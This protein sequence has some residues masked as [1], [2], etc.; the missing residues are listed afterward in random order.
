MALRIQFY[1]VGGR[2]LRVVTADS[3][4]EQDA[5]PTNVPGATIFRTDTKEAWR[6]SGTEWASANGGG[7]GGAAGD[8]LL[9]QTY[10]PSATGGMLLGSQYVP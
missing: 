7:G 3:Q 6:W 1:Y 4:V 10:N 9:A 5:A 8:I 2:Y